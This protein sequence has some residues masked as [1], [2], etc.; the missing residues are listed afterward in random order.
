MAIVEMGRDFR[1][2]RLRRAFALRR[3]PMTRRHRLR[4]RSRLPLRSARRS[5]SGACASLRRASKARRWPARAPGDAGP[6]FRL[7]SGRRGLRPL[8]DRACRFRTRGAR[9]RR[10]RRSGI[11][12]SLPRLKASPGRP[13]GCRG[14]G[15]RRRLPLFRIAAPRTRARRHGR[16]LRPSLD[17]LIVR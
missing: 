5:R 12:G 2:K 11:P 3:R 14:S 9:I 4:R 10:A 8:R 7:R 15:T 13:L 1:L 17:D 16:A 6:P